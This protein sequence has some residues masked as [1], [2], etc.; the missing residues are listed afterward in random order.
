MIGVDINILVRY[1]TQDDREQAIVVE[2]IVD[3]Y[4]GIANSIF[5]NNIVIC[6]LIWVLE[7][8]YKYSKD[9]IG[10]VIKQILSTEEFAFEN[11]ELLWMALNQYIHNILDFSDAL[12]GEIN[13]L[14]GCAETLTFDNGATKAN[15]FRLASLS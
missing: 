8:G 11:Q 2:K 14:A 9:N 13:R 12:I 6:E 3:K 4:A 15:N 7:R 5:I 10:Q 1:F